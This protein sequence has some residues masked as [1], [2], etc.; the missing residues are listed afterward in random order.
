MHVGKLIFS[1]GYYHY[2]IECEVYGRRE[3]KYEMYSEKI[4]VTEYEEYL[5][6]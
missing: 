6:E 1:R 5:V 4:Q 2:I 3:G